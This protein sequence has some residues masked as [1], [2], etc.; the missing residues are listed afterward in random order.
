MTFFLVAASAIPSLRRAV[1]PLLLATAS[2]AWAAP[3]AHGPNG[4]HLDAPAGA[5]AGSSSTAPRLEAKSES[6]ELVARLSGGEFSLFIN[7][8]ETNE[9]VLDAKVE[10]ALGTMK[11]PA[12]FHADQGDYAVADE[13]MLKALGQAGDHALV[14]TIVAGQESDLLDGTLTVSAT[15]AAAGHG[16]EHGWHA[17]LDRYLAPGLGMVA[18]VAVAWVLMRRRGQA[19]RRAAVAG[20]AQ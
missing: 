10:V 5:N 7:R 4:E 16:H 3:G 6:F 19:S 17:L 14:I 11:A 8:F 15:G 1:A 20:G 13:A 18:A 2:L 9:P 12:P